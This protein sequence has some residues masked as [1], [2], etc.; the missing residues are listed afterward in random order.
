MFGGLPPRSQSKQRLG[1]HSI[2]HGASQKVLISEKNQASS[3]KSPIPPELVEFEGAGGARPPEPGAKVAEVIDMA[4]QHLRRRAVAVSLQHGTSA[5]LRGLNKGDLRGAEQFDDPM[6]F[7]PWCGVCKPI[8]PFDTLPLLPDDIPFPQEDDY[9]S[10]EEYGN[11][12]CS[13]SHK[14]S[15]MSTE[16]STSPRRSSAGCEPLRERKRVVPPPSVFAKRNSI[17]AGACNLNKSEAFRVNMIQS[18]IHRAEKHIKKLQ[19]GDAGATIRTIQLMRPLL[20]SVFSQEEIHPEV[21]D[22][23]RPAVYRYLTGF[24]LGLITRWAISHGKQQYIDLSA[25]AHAMIPKSTQQ[26]RQALAFTTVGQLIRK[27]KDAEQ[28]LSPAEY[29]Y[30]K[31]KLCELPVMSKVPDNQFDNVI[32]EMT[33]RSFASGATVTKQGDEIDGLYILVQGQ[34]DM[35]HQ[36]PRIDRC[37]RSKKQAPCVLFAD[38]IL[39]EEDP[40]P[41]VL[42]PGVAD[43][44]CEG[45]QAT[46]PRTAVA[47]DVQVML[48]FV[49]LDTLRDLSGKARELEVVERDHLVTTFFPNA[50]RVLPS[51]CIKNREAFSLRDYRKDAVILQERSKPP[52]A[53]AKVHI[54]VSGEVVMTIAKRATRDKNQKKVMFDGGEAASTTQ[55]GPGT[56]LGDDALYGEPYH[57]TVVAISGIVRTLTVSAA[58]YLHKLLSRSAPMERPVEER[59]IE[60]HVSDR[61]SEASHRRRRSC[62]DGTDRQTS[63]SGDDKSADNAGLPQK[64]LPNKKKTKGLDAFAAYGEAPKKIFTE[65]YR[66]TGLVTDRKT[67]RDNDL[68]SRLFNKK[69]PRRVAPPVKPKHAVAP[70]WGAGEDGLGDANLCYPRE[71]DLYPTFLREAIVA[72]RALDTFYRSN[73]TG[74]KVSNIFDD[75][76]L[77]P[78]ASQLDSCISSWPNMSSCIGQDAIGPIDLQ[79]TSRDF[80]MEGASRESVTWSSLDKPCLSSLSTRPNTSMETSRANTSID[81]SRQGVSPDI[82]RPLTSMATRPGTSM[83][84]TTTRGSLRGVVPK[85]PN[86]SMGVSQQ[87]KSNSA[88]MTGG[89]SARMTLM[90]TPRRK[91]PPRRPKFALCG[92]ALQTYDLERKIAKHSAANEDLDAAHVSHTAHNFHV[93]DAGGRKSPRGP[94]LTPTPGASVLVSCGKWGSSLTPIIG[95]AT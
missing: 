63:D 91:S 44:T 65:H 76:S 35:Q 17:I 21:D 40:R 56:L 27:A 38:E 66:K 37:I 10:D 22:F 15:V 1:K 26:F 75:M 55:H 33:V 84:T 53:D 62:L 51:S 48:L 41:F 25:R 49:P 82:P 50:G 85:R 7:R 13:W 81:P 5:R 64:G 19:K 95:E 59:E 11:S 73:G 74:S 70:D 34:L 61:A 3:P 6:P 30:L 60:Q 45:D 87:D 71:F 4:R 36:D 68:R 14:G 80:S 93:E 83:G 32:S 92:H 16:S 69:L 90:S 54:I 8:A 31:G 78:D 88:K 94:V 77:D 12:K 42:T 2:S 28:V 39:D 67:L 23:Q 79:G 52:L 18:P 29:Y 9:S 47:F 57:S 89:L 20:E 86:T 46:F 72:V 58:D 43:D 24:Q